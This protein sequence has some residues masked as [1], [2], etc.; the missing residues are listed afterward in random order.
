MDLKTLRSRVEDAVNTMIRR[1]ES[2]ENGQFLKPCVEGM[3][4]YLRSS[5]IIM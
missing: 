1:D 4:C 3:S 2:T 5:V